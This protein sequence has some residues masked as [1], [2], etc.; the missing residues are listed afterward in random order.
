MKIKL[1]G[2]RGS[3][4]TPLGNDDYRKKIQKI[5]LKAV[6]SKLKDPKKINDFID[7][8]PD[9][10]QYNYGGNTT[11]VCV[12]SGT[13]K[14][15]I[16]D[17]G[18]GIRPFGDELMKG[19]FG[20]G[21]GYLPIFITHLHYDHI[22]G[23]PFFKPVYIPGNVLHFHSP[24][25]K[26]DEHL[27][28]QMKPP[29][30]PATYEGTGSTK[31]YTLMEPGRRLKFEDDFYVDCYSLKHPNSSYAYKFTEKDKTFIFATDVEITGESFENIDRDN[32]FYMNAGLLVIDSQYTLD[33]SF[34]K[35]EWGHTSYTMA[36]NCGIRWKVGNLVLTHHEPA[37]SDDKLLSIYRD[38][39]KHR[40]A[41]KMKTPAVFLAREGMEF[42]L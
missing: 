23:L 1:L 27:R 9:K 12:T 6:K 11:C 32:D 17:C 36:V 19:A 5:L 21:E 10:L 18:S 14:Q 24:Y 40:N 39:V 33:E 28:D 30:F 31:K 13:G 7:N 38:A 22:Q 16:I 25:E 8:L 2:V 4:P 20:K 37:Y 42:E 15:Y 26:L 35:F 34:K 3:L 41:M 29:F